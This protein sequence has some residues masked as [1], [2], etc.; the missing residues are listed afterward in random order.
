MWQYYCYVSF[1]TRFSTRS[2]R[3]LKAPYVLMANG[4]WEQRNS[5]P[6][7][8]MVALCVGSYVGCPRN[9]RWQISLLIGPPQDPHFFSVG[10]DVFGPW[11]V[12][13][14]ETCGGSAHSKRCAVFFTCLTT[15]AVHIEVIEDMSCSCFINALRRFIALRG[16]VKLFRSDRGTNFIGAVED[17]DGNA[18]NVEENMMKTYL[19]ENRATWL[20]NA[21]HA[22]HIGGVWER[23]IGSARRILNS[24]L[25]QDRGKELT[26]EVLV[27]FMAEVCAIL[28][29]RP[30][31]LDMDPSSPM[32][33]STNVLLTRNGEIRSFSEH[34]GIKDMYT[35]SWK[36]VQVLSDMFW[37]KWHV[38]Y[39][40]SLQKRQKWHSNKENLK[41]G[42]VVLTREKNVHR[43]LWPM[44]IVERP[45]ESNDAMVRKAVVRVAKD[46]KVYYR[47][48]TEMVLLLELYLCE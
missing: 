14:R 2:E 20:F 6:P 3:L 1:I 18:I 38:T 16:P 13:I 17:L 48:I 33:L 25:L 12:V 31:M 28:N 26:H 4:S 42:D 19:K 34:L 41:T 15:R 24:K 9:R 7:S 43:N 40:D 5:N 11:P 45:I 32:V 35:A 10:L 21:P 30:I 22:S 46:R 37:K 29:S 27:M 36:H 47:P 8:F 23:V 39:L 44:G